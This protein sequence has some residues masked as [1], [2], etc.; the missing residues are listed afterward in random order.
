MTGETADAVIVGEHILLRL[1][2]RRDNDVDELWQPH[3]DPFSQLW[4][5]QPARNDLFPSLQW[6]SPGHLWAVCDRS[7]RLIGR[8]SLRN[9]DQSEGV[10]RLGITLTPAHVGRGL[11]SEA[12]RVFLTHYFGALSFTRMVLDVAAINRRAVRS[13]ERLH[14]CMIGSEWRYA[15]RDPAT[16]RLLA[17]PEY[18]DLRCH[19]RPAAQVEDGLELEFYEMELTRADWLAHGGIPRY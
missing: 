9:V 14:F 11:G 4:N 16:V 17:Q 3:A 19:F 10:A 5:I 1:W 15:G 8:L 13:Y 7:G 12:M 6:P 18:A 2:R